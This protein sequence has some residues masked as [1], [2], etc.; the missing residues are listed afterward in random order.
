MIMVMQHN[1]LR[2]KWKARNSAAEQSY[3]AD[4]L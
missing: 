4:V 3:E 2:S 1:L